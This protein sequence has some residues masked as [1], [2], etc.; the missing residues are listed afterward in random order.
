MTHRDLAQR[1]R[2]FGMS[3]FSEISTLAVQQRAVNL[4]QGFPDFPAPD[5]IKQAAADAIGADLNQY[6]PSAGIPRLR[7]AI[8]AEWERRGWRTVDPEREIT[9]TSGAT[10]AVYAAIMALVDPGDEVICFEPAY[11]AYRADIIMAGGVPRYVRLYPPTT[12]N[13]GVHSTSV[14]WF[15]PIELAAAF[16]ARTRL[17]LLNTPHNPTGKVF[18]QAELEQIAA[19]CRQHHVVAICDEVYD[20]L[21]YDTAVHLP[22]A[23]LPDMWQRTLTINSTGKTFSLT[24]WKVGYAVGP[25]ELNQ[26]LRQAHQWITFATATPLQAALAVA[27]ET[28]PAIG[29]Y[30]ELRAAYQ[31]RRDRLAQVLRGNGLSPLPT[32]GSFFLLADI[33]AT[34]FYDDVAFCRWLTCEVGVAAIPITVF[35]DPAAQRP[36][37]PLARF[38]FAKQHA[39]IQ[40]AAERLQHIARIGVQ[41]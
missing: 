37:P 7:A 23:T 5:W 2:G 20:Q 1:V 24:G 8:A 4:G 21:I 3:I 31:E 15:D 27:L 14:W 36:A 33:T 25:T 17:I 32:E 16:T 41:Q 34:G 18:C 30:D 10:E 9:V 12:D 38:C 13:E 26:A 29:Y 28:A 6:A 22:I 11:D 40:A 19:L 35:Y 39:T